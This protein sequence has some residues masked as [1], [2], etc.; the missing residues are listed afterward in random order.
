MKK[1]CY[2]K[3]K[4]GFIATIMQHISQ[5]ELRGI[6]K[7]NGL[8]RPIYAGGNIRLF[9]DICYLLVAMEIA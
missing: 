9:F 1:E 7:H 5:S 2:I 3:C 6:H 8:T 4:N